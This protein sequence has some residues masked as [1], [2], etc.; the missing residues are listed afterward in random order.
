MALLSSPGAYNPPRICVYIS[1]EFVKQALWF[2][3]ALGVL[4]LS[5]GALS[6]SQAQTSSPTP[7][8]FVIQ[9]TKGPTASF[10]SHVQ[11]M[12][13]NGHF[14]VFESNGNV[15]TETSDERNNR[16]G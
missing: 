6:S 1:E 2:L 5:T 4:V 14:V 7:D 12:T 8:P 13:A 3:C 10:Q 16:D 9:L 15:A 11:D